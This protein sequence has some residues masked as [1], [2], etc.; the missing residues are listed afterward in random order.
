MIVIIT[1]IAIIMIIIRMIMIILIT[2]IIKIWEY[3]SSRKELYY[4]ICWNLNVDVHV[5]GQ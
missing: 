4:A 3:I 1:L 5:V 2:M